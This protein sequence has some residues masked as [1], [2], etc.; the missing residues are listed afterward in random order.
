MSA[1]DRLELI[2]DPKRR[3]VC[4][5]RSLRL[6]RAMMVGSSSFPTIGDVTKRHEKCATGGRISMGAGSDVVYFRFQRI[7]DLLDAVANDP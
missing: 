7:A 4:E 5:A 3:A 2:E 6:A 1:S